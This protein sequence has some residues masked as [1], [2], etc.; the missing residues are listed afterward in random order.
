[1]RYVNLVYRRGAAGLCLAAVNGMPL[2]DMR[3]EDVEALLVLR[4]SGEL[5]ETAFVV[6]AEEVV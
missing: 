2:A 5:H 3:P 1:M 4:A 6:D